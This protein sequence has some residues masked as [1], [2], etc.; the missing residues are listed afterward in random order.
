MSESQNLFFTFSLGPPMLNFYEWGLYYFR[1]LLHRNQTAPLSSATFF[2][3]SGVQNVVAKTKNLV[4]YS[5]PF[6]LPFVNQGVKILAAA[7]VVNRKRRHYS[8]LMGIFPL[9]RDKLSG[10][11]LNDLFIVS[12]ILNVSFFE[13]YS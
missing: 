1:S 9:S 2:T 8:Q 3:V 10:Q 12:E 6:N 13:Q 5:V 4:R 7:N 11:L